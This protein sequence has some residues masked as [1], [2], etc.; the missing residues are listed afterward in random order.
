[1]ILW[2][3]M[4]QQCSPPS[5]CKQIHL[6][7]LMTSN[8][9]FQFNISLLLCEYMLTTRIRKF[10]ILKDFKIHGFCQNGFMAQCIG[11]DKTDR[12]L[13]QAHCVEHFRE[14]QNQSVAWFYHGVNNIT[15]LHYFFTLSLTHTLY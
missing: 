11:A 1:M 15:L 4:H 2:I 6:L 7:N 13:I 8:V 12:T 5:Y 9:L 10:Q 3:P 14:P